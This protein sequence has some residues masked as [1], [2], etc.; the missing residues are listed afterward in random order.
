MPRANTTGPSVR[1]EITVSPAL[2]D[3]IEAHVAETGVSRSRLFAEAVARRLKVPL[4]D[5]I[6]TL[7][8]PKGAVEATTGKQPEK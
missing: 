5:A 3:A 1:Y 2:R 6:N 7:G 4:A 8:R